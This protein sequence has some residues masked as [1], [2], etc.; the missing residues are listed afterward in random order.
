MDSAAIEMIR[1]FDVEGLVR[2]LTRGKYEACGAG[3]LIGTMIVCEKLGAGRS[4]VLHYMNSGDVTGDMS[5]VV[6]YVS[7]AFHG[8]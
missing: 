6:G 4:K 7:C 1:T 8:E 3:P 2:E 5:G